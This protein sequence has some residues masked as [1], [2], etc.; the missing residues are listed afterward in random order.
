MYMVCGHGNRLPPWRSPAYCQPIEIGGNRLESPAR[1]D[2]TLLI[3]YKSPIIRLSGND[4]RLWHLLDSGRADVL[5]FQEASTT[6]YGRSITDPLPWRSIDVVNGE[7]NDWAG[8]ANRAIEAR[9]PARGVVNIYPVLGHVPWLSGIAFPFSAHFPDSLSLAYDRKLRATPVTRPVSAAAA[10]IRRQ[11]WRRAETHIARLA[12]RCIVTGEADS[13]AFGGGRAPSVAIG[14][15][16]DWTE[17]PPVYQ[18]RDTGRVL[19][20]H[21][22]LA[23]LP[24]VSAVEFIGRHVLPLVRREI[25]DAGLEVAG[26]GNSPRIRAIAA[27]PGVHLHGYVEDLASFLSQCDLYVAPMLEGSGV[28]NKLLEAMAAGMPVVANPMGVEGLDAAGRA[29]V[30]IGPDAP[31]MARYIVDLLRSPDRRAQMSA[32]VREH[33]VAHYGWPSFARQFHDALATI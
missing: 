27:L 20:F 23:W 14:N 31:A 28:K 13:H 2:G 32:A 24:N 6:V 19:G 12:A 33:A 29:L 22:N 9:R 16:T 30:A 8:I 15:G 3:V 17:R 5:A 18:L 1:D 7:M 21:G 11:Q 25:P 26:G 10:F 4:L